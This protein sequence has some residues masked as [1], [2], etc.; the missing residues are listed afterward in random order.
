MNRGGCARS[1]ARV[2]RIVTKPA[3]LRSWALAHSLTWGRTLNP[4]SLECAQRVA[5]TGR[6]QS[7]LSRQTRAIRT[8]GQN[9]QAV[10][11]AYDGPVAVR[12]GRG[13]GRPDHRQGRRPRHV[14]RAV[15]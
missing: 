9:A 3:T 12:L 4:L 10:V 2:R 6:T 8:W 14:D 1:S 13:H 11:L 15:G 5:E 7:G